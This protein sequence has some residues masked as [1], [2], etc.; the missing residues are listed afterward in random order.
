MFIWKK[1]NVQTVG[2]ILQ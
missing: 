1:A 2:Y